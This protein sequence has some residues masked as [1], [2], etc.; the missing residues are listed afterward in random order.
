MSVIQDKHIT[1]TALDSL[2]AQ[3]KALLAIAEALRGLPEERRLAVFRACCILHTG[4]DPL[5]WVSQ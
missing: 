3:A 4:Q 1:D 5:T 2:E